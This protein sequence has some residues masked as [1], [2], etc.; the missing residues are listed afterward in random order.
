MRSFPRSLA[1]SALWLVSSACGTLPAHGPDDTEVAVILQ[2]LDDE[3]QLAYFTMGHGS[4]D[5]PFG[6]KGMITAAGSGTARSAS[7]VFSDIPEGTY[8]VDYV[9]YHELPTFPARPSAA[10]PWRCYWDRATRLIQVV[11]G[12]RVAA[13]LE[14]AAVTDRCA[15]LGGDR[16]LV[17]PNYVADPRHPAYG[18]LDR[19]N[20]LAL[21]VFGGPASANVTVKTCDTVTDPTCVA[22]FGVFTSLPDGVFTQWP[23]HTGSG[24]A[25][26]QTVQ[27]SASGEARVFLVVKP[28]EPPQ[29]V[30]LEVE[31]PAGTTP[32]REVF[33]VR[34]SNG[35]RVDVRAE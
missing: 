33:R 27:T 9:G 26:S 4:A 30:E 34:L 29:S 14:P 10:T 3:V 35:N 22:P 1:F 5:L 2:H 13:D 20:V 28:G 17:N 16:Y 12:Y 32:A 31:Y 8:R 23:A 19:E 18:S 6:G 11:S 24:W 21:M 25:R 15:F 7:I